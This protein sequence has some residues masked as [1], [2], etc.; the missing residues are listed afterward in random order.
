MSETNNPTKFL[1]YT[2]LQRFWEAINT[3]FDSKYASKTELTDSK[4]VALQIGK[5]IN[6]ENPNSPLIPTID[7]ILG[8]TAVNE[9]NYTKYSTILPIANEVDYG[10]MTPDMIKQL[11]NATRIPEV[12]TENSGLMTPDMLEKLEKSVQ[13]SILDDS[14]V[15]TD[16]TGTYL[17]L[18]FEYADGKKGTEKID[19]S[20]LVDVYNPGTGIEVSDSNN[21][22]INEVWLNG[23]VSELTKASSVTTGD[24]QIAGG[25]L[26]NNVNESNEYWPADW[27]DDDDNKI[28][29]SGTS[30]QEILTTLFLKEI[31]G[32][33]TWGTPT[34]NPT[35]SNPTITFT[36]TA[37]IE[38][39]NTISFPTVTE[40][41]VNAGERT[42]TCTCTQGYFTSE[43]GEYISGNYTVGTPVLINGESELTYLWNSSPCRENSD[44]QITEGTNTFTVTQ[45]GQTAT[46]EAL[47]T[48]TVYAST[49]T[50]KI[51]KDATATLND[52]KPAD[53][54][55]TS[56]NSNT[57]TGKYKYFL[58]YSDN[59]D[60]SQFDSN[61][62]RQLTIKTDWITPN[63]TTTIID[64]NNAILSNGQSIVIACPT[65]YKLATINNEAG[66]NILPNFTSQGTVSVQTGSIFT[67]Y[68]VYVYPITNGAN[69]PFKNV[70][71]TK[72][73]ANV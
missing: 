40:G 54:P 42:A 34:W 10:L 23:K 17:N 15:S 67:D 36:E 51:L 59:T 21:I 55:L 26:A 11:N 27:K 19:V 66:I 3:K 33:V 16:E 63:G 35:L 14:S 49:N 32:T 52:T 73:D 50:K 45:S 4:I 58:G 38:V 30:L 18:T 37:P 13:N 5:T 9:A 72:A 71:L 57:I 8:T 29:P 25:P 69:L 53:K 1:D 39:G 6:K 70:T 7:I 2:G 12:S 48:K 20:D 68:T 60:A 46:C 47:P 28:I 41:V 61:S 22:S 44:L 62:I 64:S 43:D 65:T 24:I 56:T 31:E